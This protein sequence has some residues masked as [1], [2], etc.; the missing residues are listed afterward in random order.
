MHGYGFYYDDS[1]PETEKIEDIYYKRCLSVQNAF[2]KYPQSRWFIWVDSDVYVNKYN[3]RV[4]DQIDLSNN[5]ILYHLFHE[6]P[7]P[8]PI[9]TGV[10]FINRDALNIEKELYE[11]RNTHPWN[12]YAFEQKAMI[13]YVMPRYSD[14]IIIHD[15]YVLNCLERNYGLEV[16][17][18]ALFVHMAARTEDERNEMVNQIV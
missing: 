12:Q 16:A 10:K 13:E 15:P 1:P 6:K 5:N 9:N 2:K 3:L 7:W 11:M 18:Q 4:E 14:R 8:F 17:K